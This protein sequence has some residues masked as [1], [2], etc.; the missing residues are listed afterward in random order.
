MSGDEDLAAGRYLL[1][2]GDPE[3]ER[4]KLQATL[5]DPITRQF[6]RDA[7][8][9][10]GM[11]VLD[12]G[13]GAGDVAMLTAELVGDTGAVLGV[14]LASA[15][16]TEARRRATDRSLRNVEFRQGD[17]AEMKFEHRFDALVGRYVLMFQSDPAAML[18][19]LSALV[20]PRGIIVF[21]EGDWGAT[22]SYPPAPTYDR[23]SRWIQES[24]R[25]SGAEPRMGLK[26]YST[27]I[28]AGLAAPSMRMESI[29][30][31][32][33]DL[34]DASVK[35]DRI[36]MFLQIVA[37]VTRTLL[38]AINRYGLASADEVSID[39]LCARIYD[40]IKASGSVIVGRSEIGA[41]SRA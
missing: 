32:T 34:D 9:A 8:I 4:L 28:D 11:R 38:P 14:D 1:G 36:G 22:N 10:P 33:S 2:H 31:G 7:G 35:N 24:V 23:C 30:G 18:R 12:I 20:R 16:L 26:L 19:K 39:T 6:F 21:H 15:S 3:L 41:W 5:I 29:V 25:L 40:E 37:E 17:A 27:F 13:S